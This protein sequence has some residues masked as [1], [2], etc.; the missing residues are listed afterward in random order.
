MNP[1]SY[2]LD[3]WI[4]GTK[5]PQTLFSAVTG[6]EIGSIKSQESGFKDI[7]EFGR[8]S[9]KIKDLTFHERARALKKLALYLM[10]RKEKFYEISKFTGATKGDSWID[11]EGGIGVL[12]A[13]ASKGRR[14]LPDDTVYIDGNL[15]NLSKSG[16]FVGLHVCSPLG[17]VA[18]H[19][20]AF[21]FPVWGMLEKLA[22]TFLAGMP[23]IIKPATVSAYLTEVVFREIIDSKILPEGS[24]QLLLGSTGDIFDHLT[25]QDVVTF[26][27]SASTGQKLKSHKN[28]IQN[29]I[30]FNMEAD[31]LN[32]S[33]LGSDVKPDS[34]EFEIFI[35]EVSREMVVKTGQKCTAIR[36]TI[37]PENLVEPVISA[38][39][40][41]L[42]STVVGD[43]SI[44]G[45]R[46]GPLVGK[47]QL[48]DVLEKVSEI[49]KVAEKVFGNELKVV[50]SEGGAF[51][52]PTLFYCNN[53]LRVKEPHEVEAFGPVN[54]VMPYKTL[55]EAV[56]L[57][58]L[59]KGS[60]VG[61]IVTGETKVAR[62]IV[63]GAAPY[64]GR[65]LI[66]DKTCA[67]E[68]TGHGSPMPGLVH[69]GP[70]RAGGGEE[71]GGI[72]GVKHYMQRTAFQG[73]PT[74]LGA[75]TNSWV[76]GGDRKEDTV[77]PFRKTFNE[78]QIGDVLVTKKRKITVE[79]IDSFA[80]LSGDHFYA[81]KEE[82]LSSKS[83]FG[84]R[85][86]HG[87]FIV[88]A[89]AGLFVDPDVGPVLA[90]Y[91]LE[92]L[93]FTQPVFVDDEIYVLLTCKKKTAKEPREGEPP[94][95]VIEWDVEVKNQRDELVAT[96]QI[97][98]LVK[99]SD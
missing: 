21:N 33:I 40:K 18:L 47:S 23:C 57:A 58:R 17:G 41:K 55:D 29:S 54:T 53:P 94:Q 77:H 45:V 65:F 26:T 19:I 42:E 63:L 46:M 50:G 72:R 2:L 62:K 32:C 97:L 38:L 7:L 69:G 84:K 12:F 98:T 27:G 34:E 5:N 15:E 10:E 37:V 22:P 8:K 70:G 91:G 86:A 87:Y 93:R 66:L 85:V 59:G 43:P 81:H 89:A 1:Q 13:Y 16:S 11:I 68:S 74:V 79:D 64:H 6:E 67:K 9:T 80:D 56:E 24:V 71:M 75:I 25:E 96:Y 99:M 73:S 61:S 48:S 90:N 20:N 30:R 78:I 4:S 31:S 95:G 14:E 60:L 28:I 52:S 51:I 76:K 49:A 39:K 92:N 3:T 82:S 83:I 88:S 36:R 44:E 35:K